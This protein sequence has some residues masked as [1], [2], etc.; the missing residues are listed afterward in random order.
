MTRLDFLKDNVGY[1]ELMRH[2]KL[3]DFDEFVVN[4]WGDVCVYRVYGNN[5][6]NYEITER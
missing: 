5:K 3:W 1:S 6:D 4:R 2:T